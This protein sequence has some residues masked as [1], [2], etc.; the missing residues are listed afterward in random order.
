MDDSGDDRD[1]KGRFVRGHAP[2]A[3]SDS[4][5]F[6]ITR[7]LRRLVDPTAIAEFLNG[8]V[9]GAHHPVKARLEAAA[10]ILDRCEGKPAQSVSVTASMAGD[11]LPSSWEQLTEAERAVWLDSHLAGLALG[12]GKG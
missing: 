10:M 1:Q 9:S 7:E 5:R 8:V 12:P 6:A 11:S 4:P 2:L 3:R